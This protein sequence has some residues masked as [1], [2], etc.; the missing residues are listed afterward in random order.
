MTVER[1]T[2][3]L[4]RALA[5]AS[6]IALGIATI[7]GSG[8]G[9]GAI[10][11]PDITIPTF[12]P[13]APIPSVS[14]SPAEPT[15]QAGT[16]VRFDT[17]VANLDPP[18][19]YQWRRDG[20]DIAGATGESYL[21]GGAQ[22]GDDLARFQVSATAT[23]A[24]VTSVATLHVSPAPPTVIEDAS[25]ALADWAV[26]AT[27]STNGPT[28]TALQSSSGGNPAPSRLLV[29]Q[30]PA[31]VSALQLVHAYT[32]TAYVPAAQGAIY[33]IDYSSDCAVVGRSTGLAPMDPQYA[34]T[35]EQAGRL[36]Q[37]GRW[38]VFCGPAW[39]TVSG[40]SL[41]A[42]RIALLAGTPCADTERCP[43]FTAGGAPLRFGFATWVRTASASAA[44]TLE[45]GIDNWKVTV[46][47]R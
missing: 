22:A 24:V 27:P 39:N 25:F 5:R 6:C 8:G 7:V 30:L 1:R 21:L 29:H 2:D 16:L 13:P 38:A 23:N 4:L 17:R 41:Q 34:V 37:L 28:V 32:A 18:V 42:D 14:I 46:W 10:G 43:D 36:Y 20:V 40:Q 26:T 45:L 35:F 19:T 12:P 44:G 15:V 3:G 33:T 9:I 47:R 11:F 31:G